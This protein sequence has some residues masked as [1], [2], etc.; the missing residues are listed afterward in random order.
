MIGWL[1]SIPLSNYFLHLI[2]IIIKCKLK[3]SFLSTIIHLSL[4]EKKNNTTS[5]IETKK[6]NNNNG[7]DIYTIVSLGCF[8]L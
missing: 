7:G 4:Q 3:T 1:G 2:F 8:L 5:I 6:I